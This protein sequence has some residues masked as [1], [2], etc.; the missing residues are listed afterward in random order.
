MMEIMLW[1]AWITFVIY[2]LILVEERGN[3]S[4]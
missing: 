1:A 2:I 4:D 3:K